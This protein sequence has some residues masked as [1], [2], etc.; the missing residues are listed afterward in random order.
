M[1]DK[2][3]TGPM[4]GESGRSLRHDR[5]QR[6][7][8]AYRRRLDHQTNYQA[9]L[10]QRLK[11]LI[12]AL[13]EAQYHLGRLNSEIEEELETAQRIQEGL[14][15]KE[16]PE[17]A[18]L[19]SAAIY[20][21]AGKVGGDLYD[22]IITPR[23][24]I[25]IL[26]YDVSGHGIPAA[27]I[28]AMA[29][30]L[31]AHYIEKTD[32][33]ADVFYNVNKDLCRFIQTEQYLTAF[34]GIIDPVS[35]IMTFARAGHVPPLIY[36]E[37]DRS[38]TRLDS[39]GFFIGHSA[40]LSI[41]EYCNET[42]RL[43]TGDKLLFYTDGLTEG[44]DRQGG[45]YGVERLRNAFVACGGDDVQS[46]IGTIVDEQAAFRDG[47][48]LRD[49][50]TMLCVQIGDSR[51][52]LAESGFSGADGPSILVVSQLHEIDNVCGAILREMDRQ[53]FP[54]QSIKQFKVCIFEMLT[55]AIIHGNG[56]DPRKKVLV[57]YKVTEAEA[58]ISVVDEGKGFD[59]S[60]V[61][62]PLQPG[63]CTRDHGRG[64]FLIRHYC[65]EVTFNAAGNRIMGR[66][67]LRRE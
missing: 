19:K 1:S 41:V 22:V 26:I 25:A 10:E 39:R 21:P 44:Y 20:I 7:C 29:K 53:G 11:E 58:V 56:G 23:Q 2:S 45:L 28:G 43:E 40:L 67:L 33:P 18:N 9:G 46:V 13:K 3:E 5:L 4:P 60:G 24:K 16:L 54:D 62:D 14:L 63:N 65:D 34:L 31:F 36:H 55:N 8:S 37:K 51:R 52:L 64:I 30:M 17:M 12:S 47:T 66:K 59:Y 48:P 50:F 57:F 38:V 32:S 27:L 49:D 6:L 61:P 15:P 42:V 35:N